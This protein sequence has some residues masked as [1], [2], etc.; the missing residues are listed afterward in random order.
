MN[1]EGVVSLPQL[2]LQVPCGLEQGISCNCLT[3]QLLP[4]SGPCKSAPLQMIMSIRESNFVL[5]THGHINNATIW[6]FPLKCYAVFVVQLCCPWDRF[7]ARTDCL[8]ATLK[9]HDIILS[10][11]S[12]KSTQLMHLIFTDFVSNFKLLYIYVFPSHLGKAC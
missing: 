12:I 1:T 3:V 8:I 6:K 2:S 10:G 11:F 7:T 9:S 5:P 4:P